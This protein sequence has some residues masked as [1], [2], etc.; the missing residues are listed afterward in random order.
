MKWVLFWLITLLQ[1][2][3]ILADGGVVLFQQGNGPYQTSVLASPV[4]LRQGPIEISVMIQ[5]RFRDRYV[6]DASVNLRFKKEDVTIES[7]ATHASAQNKLLYSAMVHLPAPGA[8]QLQVEV[9][10]QDFSS[11]IRDVFEVLPPP[12]PLQAYWPYFII[13]PLCIALF[14]LH[15]WLKKKPT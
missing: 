3:L 15:Q 12:S 9:S 10:D 2:T 8:W 14:L 7:K 13:P 1:P 4:P 5:D 11:T 6:L